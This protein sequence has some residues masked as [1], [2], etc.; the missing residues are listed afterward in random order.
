M[1]W[2]EIN[3]QA[4]PHGIEVYFKVNGQIEKGIWSDFPNAKQWTPLQTIY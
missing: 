4:P 3:L 1:D 2:I